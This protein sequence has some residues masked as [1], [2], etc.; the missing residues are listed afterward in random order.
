[1]D[2]ATWS[3]TTLGSLP[4][5]HLE[6]VDN[7]SLE[8]SCGYSLVEEDIKF[9]VR[10][11]EDGLALILGL[12]CGPYNSPFGLRQSEIG[13]DHTAESSSEPNIGCP[14]S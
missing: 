1:M 9:T 7:G 13:P 5:C 3:Y 2:H 8:L 11:S 4:L 6:L 10:S 14:R 12:K